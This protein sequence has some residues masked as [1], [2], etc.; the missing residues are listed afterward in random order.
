MSTLLTQVGAQ[1]SANLPT[2]ETIGLAWTSK[3]VANFSSELPAAFYFIESIQ[4]EASPYQTEVLQ[5]ADYTI[6]VLVVCAVADLEDL[7]EELRLALVGFQPTG[8]SWEQFEHVQG[9]SLDINESIIWWRESFSV[10][11]YR[12]EV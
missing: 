10:R 6:A 2:F 4:S 5:S 8:G 3:P 1:L 12:G 11:N 7:L 9:D